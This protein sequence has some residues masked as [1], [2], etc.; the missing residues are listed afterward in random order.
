MAG[1]VLRSKLDTREDTIAERCLVVLNEEK[2]ERSHLA[3]VI[4]LT[5]KNYFIIK[6]FLSWANFKLFHQST[7]NL[8]IFTRAMTG[9]KLHLKT[10]W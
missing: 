1:C 7:A 10:C 2:F 3:Y 4:P 8:R 6:K 9:C 5:M